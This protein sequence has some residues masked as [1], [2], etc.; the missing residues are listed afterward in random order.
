MINGI[1]VCGLRELVQDVKDDAE[2]ASVEYGV[3]LD[4]LRGTRT[5]VRAANMSVGH[6]RVVR[7]F[8]FEM[9]EPTQLAGTSA[10][11]T[12]QETLLGG[13]A[14]CL[15]VTFVAGASAM[16]ITLEALSVEIEGKLDLHGFLGF[17]SDAATGF[18]KLSYRFIVKGDGSEDEYRRLAEKV[19]IH[20][21]NFATIANPVKLEPDL[22]IV[23]AAQESV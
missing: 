22:I 2:E 4:W 10:A 1:N 3:R 9:D 14:G 18:E 5:K 15:A 7:D 19:R 8:E 23:E 12:P 21:P 20:S 11:P 17:D 6:H 16:G 13:L